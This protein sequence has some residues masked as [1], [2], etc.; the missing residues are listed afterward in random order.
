MRNVMRILG[1]QLTG[2][3][4]VNRF[5]H[6]RDKALKVRMGFIGAT[7][8]FAVV[9]VAGLIAF[10]CE[11]LLPTM[12]LLGVAKILL[13]LLY[14]AASIICLITS[15]STGANALF[16]TRDVQILLPMPVGTRTIVCAR[17]LGLYLI[18]LLIELVVFVPVMVQ[19]A[20]H[21]P[22]QLGAYIP[23]CVLGALSLPVIPLLLGTVVSVLI[24]LA[25]TR[26]RHAN[27]V[28]ILLLTLV[29]LGAIAFSFSI[30]FTAAEEFDV[31]MLLRL[32]QTLTE[33][34]VRMYPLTALF[35]DAI[36]GQVSAGLLLA[37]VSLLGF[38]LAEWLMG[39][40]FMP[41]HDLF[42]A[43]GASRR[44]VKEKVW[45]VH[46]PMQTLIAREGRRMLASPI[47]AMNAVFGLVMMVVMAGVVF[48]FGDRI[49]ALIAVGELAGID[50]RGYV[51][52][53]AA[54]VL[55]LLTAMVP[56][57]CVSI[58]LEGA[59]FTGL[60]SLPVRVRTIFAAKA[61]YNVLLMLPA[62]LLSSM[63][64]VLGLSPT[65]VEAA[66]FFLLPLSAVVLA[67]AW[68]LIA[69]LL[70]PRFD[71]KS[72]TEVVK[73]GASVLV[74]MLGSM[75][76]SI[77]PLIALIYWGVNLSLAAIVLSAV[78]VLLG[79]VCWGVLL[80]WGEKRFAHIG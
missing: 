29:S 55:Y 73:Q 57:T 27:L 42:S 68:G 67:P 50:V 66:A 32:S 45:R 7:A 15:V 33:V 49:F 70:F 2:M 16:D 46:S 80:T 72:E 23:A 34:I 26:F 63:L 22:V 3:L 35:V 58:S 8:V 9:Y 18:D 43:S 4:G 52:S 38:A 37:G 71:W 60:R 6:T 19:Y 20:R 1:V 75:V 12:R 47:Y 39:R 78:Y 54:Y 61:L 36:G 69:N 64:L 74:C 13:P 41:L 76:L 10:L 59:A 44:G 31:M 21:V 48:F 56:T 77:A 30:S 65:P 11:M 53:G 51:S 5:L 40:F 17:L 28:S 79:V 62:A 25:A 14:A 24:R